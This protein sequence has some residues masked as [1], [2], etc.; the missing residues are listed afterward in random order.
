MYFG[1]LVGY[2]FRCKPLGYFHNLASRW[3]S[4]FIAHKAI[5]K[6][7]KSCGPGQP[8]NG[9]MHLHTPS[10]VLW[11]VWMAARFQ[12][13]VDKQAFVRTIKFIARIFS[14]APAAIK[15]KLYNSMEFGIKEP[16]L[17]GKRMTDRQLKQLAAKH[18][19]GLTRHRHKLE[20]RGSEEYGEN[21]SKDLDEC[22]QQMMVTSFFIK[23]LAAG[24]VC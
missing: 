12:E 24:R 17:R 22:V 19:E 4:P 3:F 8:R 9:Y 11:F 14:G 2:C 6:A 1:N 23:A 7:S 10:E 21:W 15:T 18:L 5:C 16:Y 13:L 20:S